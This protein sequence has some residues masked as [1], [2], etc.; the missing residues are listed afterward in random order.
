MS[1]RPSTVDVIGRPRVSPSWPPTVRGHVVGRPASRGASTRRP[2]GGWARS[3]SRSIGVPSAQQ[4]IRGLQGQVEQFALVRELPGVGQP[5]S[6]PAPRLKI[7]ARRGTAGRVPGW[8]RRVVSRSRPRP[9][10]RAGPGWSPAI[11]I[12][13]SSLRIAPASSHRGQGMHSNRRPGRRDPGHNTAARCG[14]AAIWRA[15][16]A[17]SSRKRSS[18]RRADGQLGS[19]ARKVRRHASS[20]GGKQAKCRHRSPTAGKTEEC[21]SRGRRLHLPR[22][23]PH[24]ILGVAGFLGDQ[25][26][27]ESASPETQERK[28]SKP[29]TP[30]D[31]KRRTSPN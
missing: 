6:N 14:H 22:R 20:E 8:A 3:R 4:D 31:N 9:A 1:E 16:S 19:S 13:P 25:S 12:L 18:G 7:R 24:P 26:E 5:G 30:P 10:S 2:D 11:G 17:P 21:R 29:D 23:P 28:S 15:T 27:R